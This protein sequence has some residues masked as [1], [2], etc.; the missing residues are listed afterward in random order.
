[1]SNP[2]LIG[3]LEATHKE[4][5]TPGIS[6]RKNTEEV[7]NLS[8]TSDETALVSPGQGSD[9]EVDREEKHGQEYQQ[10]KGEVTP[11][12]DPVDEADPLNKRK[13]SP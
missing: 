8:I 5:N 3:I 12:R 2:E 11:P 1:M 7:K 10:K 9:D 13:V 4:H 6:K